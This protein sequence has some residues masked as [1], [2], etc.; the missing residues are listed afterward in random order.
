[1]PALATARI[2]GG[3]TRQS[4]NTYYFDCTGVI[5]AGHTPLHMAAAAHQPEIVRQLI[6]SGADVRAKNRRGT[7]PLHAAAVGNPNAPDWKPDAQTA[8]IATLLNAGADP[9]AC[10][11][12]GATPL[13]RA[14][15]TRCAAAVKALIDGG[16]DVHLKNKGGSTPISLASKNTGWSGGS[17]SEKAK[18]QQ[19]K[20]LRLFDAYDTRAS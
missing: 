5:Y 15:R 19:E 4:P 17:S 11:N 12:D 13:H 2:Q 6:T 1:M 10:N 8:T 18:T 16:A 7:E 20:I 14:V 3:A 9:N